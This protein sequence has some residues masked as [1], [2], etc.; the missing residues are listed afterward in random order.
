MIPHVASGRLVLA[1]HILV[2]D[3]DDYLDVR[4]PGWVYFEQIGA[5]WTAGGQV[6]IALCLDDVVHALANYSTSVRADVAVLTE[7]M[8]AEELVDG[9]GLRGKKYD[10]APARARATREARA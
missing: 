4:R 8:H 9:L 5:V 10:A 7:L 1:D 6:F 3:A 2:V